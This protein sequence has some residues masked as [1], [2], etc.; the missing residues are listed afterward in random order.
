MF[1]NWR[2]FMK[3]VLVLL[4]LLAA[5]GFGACGGTRLLPSDLTETYY[6][7]AGDGTGN[8]YKI[9]FVDDNNGTLKEMTPAGTADDP[10]D[11]TEVSSDPFNITGLDGTRHFTGA[12]FSSDAGLLTTSVSLYTFMTYGYVQFIPV[13]SD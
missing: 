7:L 9:D 12:T 1:S 3:S 11:D 2:I 8:Y 5:F 10:S 6:F 4:A 13:Y